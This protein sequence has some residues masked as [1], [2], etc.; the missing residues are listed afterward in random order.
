MKKFVQTCRVC[1]MAKGVKHNIG[2][3]QPLPLPKKPWED[4]KMNFVLSLP[5]IEQGNDSIYVVV[6]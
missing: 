2:L 3:Y 6:D 5:R 1:H 4:V